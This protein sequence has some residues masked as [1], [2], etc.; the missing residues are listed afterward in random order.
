[1]ISEEKHEDEGDENT[2]RYMIRDCVQSILF[3]SM[4]YPHAVTTEPLQ[5][6]G[7]TTVRVVVET[8]QRSSH[9]VKSKS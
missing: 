6:K 3:K 1:M 8:V 7:G 9:T 4:M 5:E 2:T